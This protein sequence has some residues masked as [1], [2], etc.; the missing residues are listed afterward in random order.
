MDVLDSLL[1]AMRPKGVV[2]GRSLMTAPWGIDFGAAPYVR[3]NAVLEGEAWLRAPALAEPLRLSAGSMVLILADTPHALA[4]SPAARATPIA[5]LMPRLR[6]QW[7]RKP[8]RPR[9][10]AYAL[11]LH[12]AYHFEPAPLSALTGLPR[13][14]PL[15]AGR[16]T[17]LGAVVRALNAELDAPAPGRQAA[18]D[19]TVDLMLVHALRACRERDDAGGAAWIAGLR[20][21]GLGRALAALHEKPERDWRVDDLA[22]TAGMSRSAFA[23]A[24][25]AALGRPPIAYLTHWRMTRAAALLR[26]TRLA[27]SE[28]ARRC[29]YGN[30]YAF[31]TAFRRATGAPPGALRRRPAA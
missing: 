21:P 3:F 31:S 25:A 14:V 24:F 18:I 9:R 4:S 29:G 28:I 11:V 12:G 17:A 23:E 19:R 5:A 26:E 22:E 27:V 1:E 30:A 15:A 13:L 6:E 2:A 7:R 16:G 10:G 8:R 20:H